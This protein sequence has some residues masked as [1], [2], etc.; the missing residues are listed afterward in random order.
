MK[1]ITKICILAPVHIYDDVRVFQ[2]EAITLVNE[3]YEVVLFARAEQEIRRKGIHVI[4]VPKYRNRLERF[5]IQPQLMLSVLKKSPDIIHIHNPDTLIMGFIFKALGKKVI[6]DTHED[7]SK[8][9]LMRQWIPKYFRKLL[10]KLVSFIERICTLFFDEVI[11]TQKKVAER[12]GS[13]TVIIENA[14]I[15]KGTL[16][17]RSLELSKNI[18]RGDELRLIYAGKIGEA[19]GLYQTIELLEELNK[20]IDARLWLLGSESEDNSIEKAKSLT[21]WKYVDYFGVQSQEKAFAYINKADIGLI[22]ILDIGDHSQTSPNKIYEYQL[23]G[24]P[25][26]ASN[27]QEWR[28]RMEKVNSGYFVNPGN[29]GEMKEKILHLYHNPKQRKTM[30]SNGQ[31]FIIENYNW[32]IE[33]KKLIEIYKNIV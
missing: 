26:I 31:K 3:G 6:Y 15:T 21:G 32:E 20:K 2:K 18:A 13:K 5:I 4:P 9:L 30:G 17:K 29:I 22:T 24:I 11:V 8:R 7:F 33:S 16:I 27:F 1:N 12:L 23:F 19:R 25:F 28:T 10:S 14:P